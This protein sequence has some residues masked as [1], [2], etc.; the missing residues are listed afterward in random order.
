MEIENRFAGLATFQLETQS[1]L[2]AGALANFDC[3]VDSLQAVEDHV[4]VV[5]RVLA[6]QASENHRPLLHY[7]R[8]Y[9]VLNQEL[10]NQSEPPS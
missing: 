7:Q 4:L 1:P 6:L 5:G 2:L 8:A 3:R 9:H 10:T